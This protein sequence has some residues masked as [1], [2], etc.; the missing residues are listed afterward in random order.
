MAG[1]GI[2]VFAHAI[3]TFLLSGCIMG[4]MIQREIGLIEKE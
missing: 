2:G 4:R 1:W 3:S